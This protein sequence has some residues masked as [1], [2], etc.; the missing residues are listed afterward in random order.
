MNLGEV[1][2]KV[3]KVVD[4]FFDRAV[5][6]GTPLAGGQDSLNQEDGFYG[7]LQGGQKGQTIKGGQDG[8]CK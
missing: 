8:H 1:V 3:G 6:T 2:K 7:H 5:E 4:T